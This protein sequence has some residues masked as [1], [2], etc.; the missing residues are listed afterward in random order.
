MAPRFSATTTSTRKFRDFDE[1]E[2]QN[3]VMA[4]G[5]PQFR[6]LAIAAGHH[7]LARG[8]HADR[9]RIAP[10]LSDRG[11]LPGAPLI[12]YQHPHD[13][14]MNL[15]GSGDDD[16]RPYDYPCRRL[17]RGRSAA[18]SPAFMHR[19][20]AAENP[21]SPLAHHYLDST[22]IT[23]GVVRGG[24][25][26]NGFRLDA[27]VFRG[28]EPDDNR[29]D[30]DLGALDSFAVQLSW[31]GGPWSAQ[32]SNGWLT[33]PEPVTPYDATQTT[34]SVA[35]FAGDER[36]S[37]AW[38]A[39]FGQKRE[40]HG[41]FEGYLLE[42]TWRRR[43]RH[44]LYSRA[45]WV[46]KDIL[47]AGY[48]PIGTPHTHRKSPIGAISMGYVNDLVRGRFGM[49][50]VGGDVTGYSTA[51]NLQDWSGSPWSFHVF[52]RYRAKPVSSMTHG[53]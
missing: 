40:F 18:G 10:G 22:H 23:P 49:F 39:A 20:S 2:S 15:G 32:V 31:A 36:R 16:G 48:H 41:N 17:C 29:T 9:S 34:A 12:D 1:V 50:G 28:R 52:V 44:T 51:S 45:E 25:G 3:W 27:G 30:F 43:A 26:R 24:I 53:H 47:D 33:Q 46:I 8:G 13:L 35:Y 38:L 14:V 7:A 42:G 21:Q 4:R 11:N 19:P 37:T 6:A 5:P